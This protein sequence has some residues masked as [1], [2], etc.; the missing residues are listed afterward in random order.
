MA[1]ERVG[2]RGD[3]KHDISLEV[4]KYKVIAVEFLLKNSSKEIMGHTLIKKIAMK[5]KPVLDCV[6]DLD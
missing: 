4:A 2:V 3:A 6:L 5:V 1:G